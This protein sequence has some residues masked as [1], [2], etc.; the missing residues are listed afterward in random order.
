[1]Y[2]PGRENKC[3]DALSR[4]PHDPAP[5][6]RITEGETQVASVSTSKISDLLGEEP[7]SNVE[8]DSFVAE[9]QNDPWIREMLTC[10]L[11]KKL[12]E[13]GTRARTIAAQSLQFDVVDGILYFIDSKRAKTRMVVLH[14]LRQQL[15]Q[16]NHSGPLGGHFSGQCT[17]NRLALRWWN[18]MFAD[19]MRFCKSCPG[20]ATVSGTGSCNKPPLCPRDHFKS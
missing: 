17:F 15:L 19:T 2:H 6:C 7:L 1:M 5:R 8:P 11:E 9:Q 10:L 4:C 12:P 13:D 18:G 20:Y 16:E 3:A 14:H